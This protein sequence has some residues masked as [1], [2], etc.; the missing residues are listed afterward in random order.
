MHGT[1]IAEYYFLGLPAMLVFVLPISLLLSLLYSLT[2]H[3]RHNEITAMRAAGISL[4][5]LCMPYIAVGLIASGLL[6][7]MNEYWAPQAND[8]AETIKLRRVQTQKAP[9]NQFPN[10][11]FSN[12]REQRKWKAQVYY[13]DRGEM[14]KPTVL[15]TLPDGHTIWL[16]ADRAVWTNNSWTFYNAAQFKDDKESYLVPLLQTNV[17]VMTAFTETPTEINNY[18][19]LSGMF[20]GLPTRGTTHSDIPVAK[21]RQYL[22][23]N[24]NPDP[25][26]AARLYTN[27]Y[28]RLAMPW[29][30]LVVVLIA[31]PFGAAQGRRNVFVGVASSV[32]ICVV[33]FVLQ[34]IGLMLGNV[35]TVSPWLAAWMPNLAFSAVALWMAARVR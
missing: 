5:R 16:S 30:C 27:L 12:A 10:F 25:P 31:I 11:A 18:V 26:I 34:Q 29:T 1:D 28:G 33:Y 20:S 13:S 24:P 7:V 9:P 3:A 15:W 19:K 32:T 35:G 8:A 21:V 4:W 23:F 14:L 22:R 2:N 6:Y 17:L